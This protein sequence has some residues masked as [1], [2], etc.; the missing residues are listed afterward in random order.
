MP[1]TNHSSLREMEKVILRQTVGPEGKRK[2]GEGAF[3]RASLSKE[4]H[5]KREKKNAPAERGTDV[6]E[7]AGEGGHLSSTA[8]EEKFLAPRRHARLGLANRRIYISRNAL[9]RNRN[10][11]QRE[12]RK[13]PYN[14]TT[15]TP[16][17]GPSDSLEAPA[18]AVR[19]CNRDLSRAQALNECPV[20][21]R[22]A[23]RSRRL[24]RVP[25]ERRD[26]GY[27]RGAH[28]AENASA[29]TPD[30]TTTPPL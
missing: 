5:G 10:E 2:G 8:S 23:M 19:H 30:A 3:F 7:E 1:F 15:T 22:C 28:S 25:H 13:V 27:K 14:P 11:R 4:G 9:E 17:R 20:Q 21:R 26:W 18:A 24:V 12:V 16:D 6:C 29:G